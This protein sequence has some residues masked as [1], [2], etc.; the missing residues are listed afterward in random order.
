MPITV[1]VTGA[2]GKMT[3]E[4]IAAVERD[5]DLTLVGAVSRSANQ[6]TLTTAGGTSVPLAGSIEALLAQV[7]PDVLVDFTSAGYAMPLL[8]TAIAAG[9]RPVIG[10]SGVGDAEVAELSA[11][12]RQHGVGGVCAANFAMG[13]VVM[14]H[15][16][17]VA[18]RYF[19][20]MSVSINGNEAVR[21][22]VGVS[23]T[24][25]GFE[26]FCRGET[27]ISNASRAIKS[28]EADVCKKAGIEFTEVIV[29]NDG[30]AVVV[31][32]DNTWASCLTM[33]ELN[34]IWKDEIGRAHV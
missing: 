34:A 21:L 28:S 16:A 3:R 18:A 7:K 19:E 22:A 12:C 26:K 5:P 30:L 6:T 2:S 15:L 11:L 4:V 29:A 17:A 20:N 9:V 1:A 8:R 23:G 31:N 13:G 25:G 32:K 24:G 33:K 10:T 14:M 27:D